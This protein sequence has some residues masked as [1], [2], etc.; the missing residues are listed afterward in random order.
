M[1]LC[2]MNDSEAD[3]LSTENTW[4]TPALPTNISRACTGA[5][6]PEQSVATWSGLAYRGG[7]G[8]FKSFTVAGAQSCHVSGSTW[9]ATPSL[10]ASEPVLPS[11]S[12]RW[13]PASQ[14]THGSG[15]LPIAACSI[16]MSAKSTLLTSLASLLADTGP[17]CHT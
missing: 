5:S 1:K 3:Q 9:S 4:F 14:A 17:N 13:A 8:N 7:R 16:K 2:R 6:V 11:V 10:L 12:E 15:L